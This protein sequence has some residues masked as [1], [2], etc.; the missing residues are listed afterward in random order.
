VIRVTQTEWCYY[1]AVLQH[2]CVMYLV[3]DIEHTIDVHKTL[4]IFLWGQAPAGYPCS[5]VNFRSSETTGFGI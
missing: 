5:L 2:S 1:F 3:N 4:I